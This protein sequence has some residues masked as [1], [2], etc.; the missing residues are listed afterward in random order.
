MPTCA[1][2]RTTRTLSFA[3]RPE[4]NVAELITVGATPVVFA[5]STTR[6]TFTQRL[7]VLR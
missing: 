7:I 2:P 1:C 5:F 4:R 6:L 3:L